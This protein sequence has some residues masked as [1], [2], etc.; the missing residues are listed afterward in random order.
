MDELWSK[1]VS[2]AN[3]EPLPN[4]TVCDKVKILSSDFSYVAASNNGSER[5]VDELTS[6]QRTAHPKFIH[7]EGVVGKFEYRSTDG[8]V[9]RKGILRFGPAAKGKMNLL[10]L[11]LKFYNSDTVN[12]VHNMVMLGGTATPIDAGNPPALGDVE[13]YS[14]DTSGIDVSVNR[15]TRLLSRMFSD[16]VENPNVLD[17]SEFYLGVDKVQFRFHPEIMAVF[18]TILHTDQIVEN[19]RKALQ[20]NLFGHLYVTKKSRDVKLG[21]IELLDPFCIISHYANRH[22]FFQHNLLDMKIENCPGNR[23]LNENRQRCLAMKRVGY[24]F[25]T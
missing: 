7:A 19:M 2:G 21:T 5:V 23:N 8:K 16:L 3:Y 18:D 9:C 12:S 20:S 22:L 15:E 25:T 14:T 13:V 11:A 17:V 4:P 6:E 1:I 10:G 24:L